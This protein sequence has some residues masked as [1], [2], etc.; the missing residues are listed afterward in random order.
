MLEIDWKMIFNKLNY[1]V[2]K[3]SSAYKKKIY[4]I[5]VGDSLIKVDMVVVINDPFNG[6]YTIQAA[7]TGHKKQFQQHIA[8]LKRKIA[9]SGL[10][11][12]DGVDGCFIVS[13]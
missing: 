6:K 9:D 10:K 13:F 12:E 3:V 2:S 4:T 8:T 5:V 1:N 7:I 11:V